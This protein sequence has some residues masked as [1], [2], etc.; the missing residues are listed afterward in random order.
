MPAALD[1]TNERY[2]SLVAIERGETKVYPSGQRRVLWKFKCD[3]GNEV[4][5][6]LFD[7]RRG[8][9]KSCGC[10]K[11]KRAED[12]IYILPDGESSFNALYDVYKKRAEKNNM[13]FTITKELFRH[14]TKSNCHYCGQEPNQ[15][16]L[17]NKN[18]NGHYIY[19]GIDRIDSSIGYIGSNILPCCKQ[20]NFS[21]RDLSYGDFIQWLK[22]AHEHLNSIM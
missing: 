2:G 8:D 15:K 13:D 1:I 9:T 21:K 19:N 3:C 6:T 7:I 5:K 4:L 14:I 22:K 16:H 12:G 20:C 17:A 18:S 11:K 10:V